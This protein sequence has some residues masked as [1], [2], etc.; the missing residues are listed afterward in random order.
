MLSRLRS[1]PR[2]QEG[3]TLIELLVVVLIIGILAAIAIPQFIGQKD[4]ANSAAAT[5]LVRDATVAMESSYTDAQ[6]YP[7]TP[8]LAVTALAAINPSI[9][10]K[11]TT[12]TVP[13]PKNEVVILTSTATT[14]S[15][16]ATSGSKTY[17]LDHAANGTV[18]RTCGAGCT[19]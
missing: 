3:F 15:L 19:W 9:A 14:Y 13:A 7:T 1:R 5:A 11:A 2:N 4:K 18:S 8:A 17:T 6:T 12:A 10:Y 16:A